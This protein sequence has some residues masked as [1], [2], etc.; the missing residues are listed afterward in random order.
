MRK[1][2]LANEK[3]RDAEIGFESVKEKPFATYALKSGKAHSSVRLLK[4]TFETEAET[5][6]AAHGDGLAAALEAG[7]PEIDMELEGRKLEGLSK[8]YLSA[9]GK[10]AHAVT[11][12][13][14]VLAPDGTEKEVRKP[15]ETAANVALADVPVRWTGKTFP[16]AAALRKFVFGRSYQLRHVN[17]LTYDFL[18]EMAKKLEESGSLMLVGGGEKGVGPLVFANNGNGYRGFLEGRTQGEKY[19]LVLHLTNL[20]LKEIPHD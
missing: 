17:G 1:L 8:V 4:G 5:L 20:E 3:K 10:V 2:H 15:R 16:K 18:F 14:R 11:L 7:D 13:E 12:S 19:I 6:A 9:D